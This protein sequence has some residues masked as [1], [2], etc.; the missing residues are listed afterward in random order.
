[1]STDNLEVNKTGQE[2]GES[3]FDNR[4]LDNI[5][6]EIQNT[7][8]ADNRPWVI[9]YSGGKDST[10]A[11]QLIW[12]AIEDLPEEKRDKPIHVISSDT[13]V[14]TPKIVNHIISTLENINEYAEKK[15]LPFTAHKVTLRTRRSNRRTRS[16][17]SR[18][19]HPRT[20]YGNAQHRWQRALPPQQIR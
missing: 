6:Q 18:I 20:G 10:T 3:V 1:M 13:L 14:E 15:N 19:R 12:Y 17:Q 8:L 11:L 16:T 4:S 7:Y 5:Y 9:G 2:K